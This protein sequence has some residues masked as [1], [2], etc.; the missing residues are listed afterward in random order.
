M[1]KNS[2]QFEQK[3]PSKKKA[4]NCVH[5]RKLQSLSAPKLREKIIFIVKIEPYDEK[6][7]QNK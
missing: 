6:T 5:V 7:K 2:K 4:A 3:F 1:D